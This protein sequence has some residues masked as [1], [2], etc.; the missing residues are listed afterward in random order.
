M[1]P[2]EAVIA[3]RIACNVFSMGDPAFAIPYFLII[4]PKQSL[5]GIKHPLKDSIKDSSISLG[6]SRRAKRAGEILGYLWSESS[7]NIDK[8]SNPARKARRG[9]FVVFCARKQQKL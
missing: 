8:C 6:E 4:V 5:K 1:I 7:G 2:S 3:N 9:L